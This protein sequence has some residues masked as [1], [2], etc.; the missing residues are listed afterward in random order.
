MDATRR[1][2][3]ARATATVPRSVPDPQEDLV[4][5]VV[6][7]GSLG[8][9]RT[10]VCGHDLPSGGV[11]HCR[12]RSRGEGYG[13]VIARGIGIGMVKRLERLGRMYREFEPAAVPLGNR[14]ENVVRPS[15]PEQRD[16]DPVAPA[17]IQLPD[18]KLRLL[19]FDRS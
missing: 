14:D 4:R 17:M 16:F 19:H 13:A 6:P 11:A 8:C 1:D 9:Y 12:R 15:V 7:D 3:S 18:R 2:S 5:R 10:Q